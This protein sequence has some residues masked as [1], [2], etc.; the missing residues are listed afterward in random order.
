MAK[1][2]AAISV[3]VLGLSALAASAQTT[4]DWVPFAAQRTAPSFIDIHDFTS[5]CYYGLA[6]P[7]FVGKTLYGVLNLDSN[8]DIGC[9]FTLT[10]KGSAY[11]YKEVYAFKEQFTGDANNAHGTPIQI[12]HDLYDTS[13]SGGAHGE[14]TV[15]RY[16]LN[17]GKDEVLHSFNALADGTSPPTGLGADGDGDLFGVVNGGSTKCGD[18]GCGLVFELAFD[19]KN[20]TY[21]YHILHKF[22]PFGDGNDPLGAPVVFKGA[23]YGTTNAGGKHKQGT[24]YELVPAKNG[25]WTY[26]VIHQFTGHKDGGRSQSSL[27]IHDNKLYSTTRYGGA[28]F[29]V[30]FEMAPPKKAGGDWSFTTLYEFKHSPDGAG[31][32]Q[33]PVFAKNG[34][35]YGVTGYGGNIYSDG[36]IYSLDPKKNWKESVLYK[37]PEKDH[38]TSDWGNPSA[39]VVFGPDGRLYGLILA[40]G[41]HRFG[42]AFSFKP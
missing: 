9:I 16:S 6:T 31:P 10:P 42:Y 33:A 39:G 20:G 21:S 5:T 36:T 34:T 24:V 19:K 35:L 8:P 18:L 14:G 28:S 1:V 17:T 32:L 12:G 13:F 3:A 4:G 15:F 7:M 38:A 25:K 22:T 37:F 26:R 41:K 27:T 23:V 30:V 29:G 2:A 11:A 40:A